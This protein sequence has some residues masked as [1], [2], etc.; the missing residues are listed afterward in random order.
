MATKL[1]E[2]VEIEGFEKDTLAFLQA[3]SHDSVCPAI[4]MNPG[5]SYTSELEPDQ[6]EGWC[7]ECDT[8][9]MKSGFVLAGVI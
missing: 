8:G 1:E 2:L 7:E 6:T 9:S 4:C 5:C 3:F